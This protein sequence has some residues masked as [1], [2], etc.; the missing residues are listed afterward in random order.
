MAPVQSVPSGMPQLVDPLGGGP[1]VPSVAPILMA[2]MPPQ[3][4]VPLEQT[5]PCCPQNEATLH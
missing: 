3:Q 1:Q 2:Q 5:S 4:S